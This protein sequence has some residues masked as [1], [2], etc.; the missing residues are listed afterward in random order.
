MQIVVNE[1]LTQYELSG[2]GKLVVILHG[3]GDNSKGVANLQKEIVKTNQVLTV[4]LPG[5]GAT[6]A[7]KETW[8]LDN[9]TEFIHA[10]IKKLGF[11]QTYAVIGHSNGGALA[12]RATARGILKPE[13]LLLIGASGIRS[14]GGS[15]RFALKAVAKIGNA[16]T[17]WIPQRYRQALRKRLYETAG[18]DM[19]IVPELQETFKKTVSQDVQADAAKIT[20]PTLLIYGNDDKATPISYGQI[21]AKLIKGSRLE[22][23]DDAGHFVHHDQPKQTIKIIKEFLK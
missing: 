17:F 2:K 22:I 12:I 10:V 8:G 4:D 3:W 19:L 13:K 11:Q 21:F 20:V 16:I 14:R 15:R 5:F 1:L 18:S 23:I 7:P 6:Q 9:Y